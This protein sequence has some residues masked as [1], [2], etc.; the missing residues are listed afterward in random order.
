M[1]HCVEPS[2]SRVHTRIAKLQTNTLLAP[3][4]GW[5][6]TNTHHTVLPVLRASPWRHDR[7]LQLHLVQLFPTPVLYKEVRNN[8]PHFQ[9]T[10]NSRCWSCAG[11]FRERVPLLR[12]RHHNPRRSSPD[13]CRA[14][15]SSS[16]PSDYSLW[17]QIPELNTENCLK[18]E[19]Y[20]SDSHG[21][22]STVRNIIVT[23]YFFTVRLLNPKIAGFAPGLRMWPASTSLSVKLNKESTQ[24]CT[25]WTQRYFY[26]WRFHAPVQIAI[27]EAD[28]NSW[29]LDFVSS[30]SHIDVSVFNLKYTRDLISHHSRSTSHPSN[31]IQFR[32]TA[33]PVNGMWIKQ[34]NLPS[35]AQ[36]F[37][38]GSPYFWK[39]E[40][41]DLIRSTEPFTK[42]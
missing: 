38:K 7:L 23:Q 4:P 14:R 31:G 25:R 42:F 28:K 19:W 39:I 17:N 20:R 22:S 37:F 32:L 2:R 16:S 34:K 1:R 18:I 35:L 10:L 40:T 26:L 9:D 15:A 27:Q 24:S 12:W 21:L 33:S 3:G 11:V 6:P 30:G 5:Y 13:R 29:M 36:S 41:L 8:W